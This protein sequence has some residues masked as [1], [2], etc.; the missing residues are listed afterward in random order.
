[1]AVVKGKT[2]VNL[3][4]KGT[5]WYINGT[6]ENPNANAS[7]KSD[8]GFPLSKLKPNTKYLVKF[9][10]D[11]SEIYRTLYFIQGTQTAW[12]IQKGGWCIVTTKSELTSDRKSIHVYPKVANGVTAESLQDVHVMIIEYQESMENWDIPYFEGMQ[13][14]VNPKVITYNSPMRFGKGGR[15]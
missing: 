8:E 2:L 15:L 3:Q 5:G 12:S 10:K 14:V 13:S 11:I 1:M 4:Q 9:S 6:E 7:Y